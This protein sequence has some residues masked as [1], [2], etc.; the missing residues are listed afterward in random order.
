M[1]AKIRSTVYFLSALLFFSV[2]T[3]GQTA[4]ELRFQGLMT[5][6]NGMRISEDP[7]EMTV[8]L[9]N[10][11]PGQTELW[12]LS[13]QVQTDEAGWIA[14]TIPDIAPYILN[15]GSTGEAVVIT[16]EFFPIDKTRWLARGDDF[17]VS[18]TL[19]PSIKGN[20][21]DLKM[22]RMEGSE[23]TDHF[24]DHLSVFKDEYP[25]AYITGGFLL[26][27]A[28]PVSETTMLDLREW[29]APSQEEGQTAT[30]GVRKGFPQGGAT[31]K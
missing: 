28:L 5:D 9:M 1:N 4:L 6:A 30:R 15:N 29:I 17:M 16:L 27:D 11:A 3:Y 24:A 22:T 23:L 18:Y 14:F 31:R 7:F 12:K 26:S 25:F 20:S 2:N 13:S 21:I 10:A 19:T 8:K